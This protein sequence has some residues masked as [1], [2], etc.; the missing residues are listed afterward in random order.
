MPDIQQLIDDLPAHEQRATS[1]VALFIKS[2]NSR[3]GVGLF[4]GM[5]RYVT[6]ETR[7]VRA[8][9]S[10]YTLRE[11]WAQLCR[12]M[13]V[14]SLPT[15]ATA[16]LLALIAPGEGEQEAL[17]ALAKNAPYIVPLAREVARAAKE[18]YFAE[19]EEMRSEL[20]QETRQ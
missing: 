3:D 8:A 6:L 7:V 19:L 14:P 2:Y 4:S 20:F 18:A 10:R 16:E 9:T 11:F 1:L 17:Q 13:D 12:T 5:S 15:K